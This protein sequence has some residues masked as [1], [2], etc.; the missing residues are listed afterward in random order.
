[1]LALSLVAGCTSAD[2]GGND[3][4][5]AAF[6]NMYAFTDLQRVIA[7]RLLAIGLAMEQVLGRTPPPKR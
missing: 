4:F 3:A 1:M 7:E 6:M 5:K 2:A